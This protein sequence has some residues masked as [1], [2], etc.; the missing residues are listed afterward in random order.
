LKENERRVT[1]TPLFH[2]AGASQVLVPS[3]DPAIWKIAPAF[4]EK[5]PQVLWDRLS[6]SYYRES[7]RTS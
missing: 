3:V 4:D 1:S 2:F 5:D 7:P 6:R